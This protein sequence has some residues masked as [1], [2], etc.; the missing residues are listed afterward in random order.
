M[1]SMRQGRGSDG[2]RHRRALAVV[3]VWIAV[4]LAAASISV[5]EVLESFRAHGRLGPSDAPAVVTTIVA[6][7]TATGT[8]IG[9]T[10]TAYAK[11]VRARGQADADLI[12]ARAEMV[13]AEADAVRARA[14]LPQVEPPV[15]G[16]SATATAPAEPDTNQPASA[17][18]PNAP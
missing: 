11:Y 3:G 4:L 9:V 14:G 5:R 13:R 15:N 8:L 12:R 10:L 7:G 17:G 16:G 6:L 18:E 1:M 2:R